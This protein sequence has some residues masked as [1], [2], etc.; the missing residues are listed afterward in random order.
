MEWLKLNFTSCVV[1]LCF[2]RIQLVSSCKK[3]MDKIHGRLFIHCEKMT[4]TF[5]PA[6]KQRNGTMHFFFCCCDCEVCH[7]ACFETSDQA[8]IAIATAYGFRL[9]ST[10]ARG[11]PSKTSTYV[12]GQHL[13]VGVV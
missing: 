8:V 4:V 6:Q 13:E 11:R 9:S 7:T 1:H 3:F 2:A 12:L 5:T 10:A